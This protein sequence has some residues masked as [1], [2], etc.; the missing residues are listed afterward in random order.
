MNP[1]RDWAGLAALVLAV[2]LGI[3]W[4]VAIVIAATPWGPEITPDSA[5]LLN[6]IGQVLAGALATFLGVS[7]GRREIRNRRATDPP[8]AP[9]EI[10]EPPP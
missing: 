5:G 4:A 9:P 3:G 6:G 10:E 1:P 8:P 2:C 7:S